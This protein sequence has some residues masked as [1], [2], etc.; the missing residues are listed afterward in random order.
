[1]APELTPAPK[2]PWRVVWA[3]SVTQ[4][5]GWGTIYYG[6]ALLM[7]PIEREFG[8]SRDAVSAAYSLGLLV[9]GFAALPVGMI[10]DRLGGRATMTIGSIAGGALFALLGQVQSYP[11]FVA[12][13]IALGAT[14]ALVLYEAAFVVITLAFGSEY[15]KGI[16]VCTFA[17][18]LASS[19]FWPITDALLAAQGWRDTALIL[20]LANI[21]I[22]GPL[23]FFLLP[24]AG[25]VR[26]AVGA[27]GAVAPRTTLG[28]LL[29]LRSFWLLALSFT[30]YGFVASALSVHQIPL[31]R[32]AGIADTTAVIFASL[33]GV[34]QVAG[35]VVEFL[36]GRRWTAAQV[37]LAMTA[38]MPASMLVLWF[39]G[40]N[41]L[42]ILL[43]VVGYGMAN[44][45]I[46]IVRGAIPV[47]LYGREG[48]G[49]ISGALAAPSVVARALGPW[50]AA[51]I[52]TASGGYSAVILGLFGIGLIGFFAFLGA[53]KS[54]RTKV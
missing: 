41:G 51:L 14:M 47:E 25:T 40:A 4:V 36:F 3:L 11:A 27:P 42:L 18:G 44:G 46:T 19:I 32:E 10:M 45:V 38:L 21:L 30:A 13:W 50:V 26:K 5:V 7:A 39:A 48:Y 54:P 29:K 1:M 34:M 49:A 9:A 15:R 23:H 43:Y 20:G 2:P 17:G 53:V 12:I 28:D 8:W 33:V 24:G 22:C 16:T 52:W 35:R 6:I 37:G 31:L